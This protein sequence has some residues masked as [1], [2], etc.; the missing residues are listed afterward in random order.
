MAARAGFEL[1]A[2]AAWLGASEMGAGLYRRIGFRD[3]GLTIVEFESP[4][5]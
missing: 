2:Q 3:L 4:T 1:G 5:A